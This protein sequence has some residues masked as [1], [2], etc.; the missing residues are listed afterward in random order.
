M[1]KIISCFHL[2]CIEVDGETFGFPPQ[3]LGYASDVD[4]IE[5]GP[6]GASTVDLI[7]HLPIEKVIHDAKDTL[8]R[9]SS[10]SNA[11]LMTVSRLFSSH[12]IF[13]S[14]A[15]PLSVH[16]DPHSHG[17]HRHMVSSDF[18]QSAL[19]LVMQMID[20]ELVEMC[21]CAPIDLDELGGAVKHADT[22]VNNIGKSGSESAH[23]HTLLDSPSGQ[24]I[25]LAVGATYFALF[26]LYFGYLNIK[27][28]KERLEKLKPYFERVT[29]IVASLKVAVDQLDKSNPARSVM[30]AELDN[31][32]A[33]L[34]EIRKSQVDGGFQIGV[35]AA[36]AG[37]SGAVIGSLFLASLTP[38][39]SIFFATYGLAHVAKYSTL[40][41]RAMKAE[42]TLN[43]DGDGGDHDALKRVLEP[44]LHEKYKIYAGLIGCFSAF[45]ASSVMLSVGTLAGGALVGGPIGLGV[46]S[47]VLIGTALTAAYL[48]N[49]SANRFAPK[50]Q[51]YQSS[52][53]LWGSQ[54][55][56]A[57]RMAACADLK[58]I[59]G[60]FEKAAPAPRTVSCLN[61]LKCAGYWTGTVL[62][63][64]TL[65]KFSTTVRD[66]KTRYDV[67]KSRIQDDAR[68]D[69]VTAY[70]NRLIE[71]SEEEILSIGKDIQSLIHSIN[72]MDDSYSPGLKKIMVLQLVLKQLACDKIK[73]E[74][75]KARYITSSIGS[76]PGI[77]YSEFLKL[78]H[79][80]T[81]YVETLEVLKSSGMISDHHRTQ[82]TLET[83]PALSYLGKC[84][85]SHGDAHQ[86]KCSHHHDHGH[87]H[88]HTDHSEKPFEISYDLAEAVENSYEAKHYL[89]A[90]D[91][92][93]KNDL[94]RQMDEQ[95]VKRGNHLETLV[96]LSKA[97]RQ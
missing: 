23:S 93:I 85:H 71:T 56:V 41:G 82:A 75:S 55:S 64:G 52:R 88:H 8:M 4:G 15:K 18:P 57:S 59:A 97:E 83:S 89:A 95:W 91:Y 30:L 49:V 28:G 77:A 2:D 10:I 27:N 46:A 39:S 72:H 20:K 54:Q 96:I 43:H 66:F 3:L 86:N 53:L 87:A 31:M 14:E 16:V 38:V 94:K 35:G 78:T 69:L 62:T 92:V 50:N 36:M 67:S 65:P 45:T 44:F 11:D 51:D 40:M 47:G 5:L 42:Y 68:K 13:R 70:C 9:A 90:F 58:N 73:D 32:R 63:L 24:D 7:P 17:H 84:G 61:R 25:G 6:I 21:L 76:L 60:S 37:G 1:Q 33:Y 22:A 19:S 74:V 29:Q 26:G 12:G 80:D 81:H 48:N 34:G 79:M